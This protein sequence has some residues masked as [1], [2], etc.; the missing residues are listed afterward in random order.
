[1]PSRV[2]THALTNSQD[3]QDKLKAARLLS[4][5]PTD[6]V[7]LT[8]SYNYFVRF[9]AWRHPR[10]P[11]YRIV[12][13]LRIARSRDVDSSSAALGLARN[14]A[15]TG[16][17]L[18]TLGTPEARE[19]PNYPSELMMDVALHGTVRQQMFLARNR[20]LYQDVQDAFCY[21]PLAKVRR[22][23][24]KNRFISLES[25]RVLKEDS[26]PPV[27]RNVMGHPLSAPFRPYIIARL[28]E[29]AETTAGNT[30]SLGCIAKYTD[31][32]EFLRSAVEHSSPV[33]YEKALGN[34]AVPV[35][36][37]RDACY[38]PNA[39][40]RTLAAGNAACPEEGQ[41]VAALLR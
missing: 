36:A 27:L 37:L 9:T 28:S 38:S 33:V 10:L 20:N 8:S 16:E 6:L 15:M 1:M 21:H 17:D 30:H 34:T 22:V 3:S 14:P 4:T 19:H 25:I 26:S 29:L 31:D 12:E 40:K 11:R 35:E 2:D 41:V 13:G 7:R 5:S 32:E 24:A 23:F 18:V 39:R